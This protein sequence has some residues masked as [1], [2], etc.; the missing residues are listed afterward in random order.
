MKQKLLWIVSGLMV[1]GL[2]AAC[3]TS[4]TVQSAPVTTAAA[5]NV[6][7]L[8]ATGTGEVYITPDI[9]S[10]NIG[11]HTEASDVTSALSQ[12]SQQAQSISD[13]LTGLGVDAKDIQTSNFNVYPVSN[14]GPD[15]QVTSKSYSVDNTVYVTVRDLNKI[16]DLLDAVVKSGANTINGITF[17]VQDKSAAE[18]QARNQAIQAAQTQAESIAKAAGVTLGD[19]QTISVTASGTNSF[20]YDKYN[21]TYGGGVNVP[22]SAGQLLISIDANLTYAIK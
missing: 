17:D 10:I 20:V 16:G 14:Y 9:A 18:E 7:T 6:R 21:A 13:T 4:P 8:S 15:G 11:V 5:T 2:L 3:S 19:L 22:V 12:N 1:L